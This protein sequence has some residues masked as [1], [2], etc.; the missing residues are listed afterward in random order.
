MEKKSLPLLKSRI[1]K[2]K[3]ITSLSIPMLKSSQVVVK[4]G[5]EKISEYSAICTICWKRRMFRE[6][7]SPRVKTQ[8]RPMRESSSQKKWR[9]AG[10]QSTFSLVTNDYTVPVI[11]SP[12]I[13]MKGD[14]LAAV[15]L[16]TIS[17]R[18]LSRIY[19]SMCEDEMAFYLLLYFINFSSDFLL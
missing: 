8:R 11:C 10:G 16:L 15:Q 7:D 18:P 1:D 3:L 12:Y 9:E 14:G 4:C 13:G 19:C 17:H 2:Q 6:K 5:D